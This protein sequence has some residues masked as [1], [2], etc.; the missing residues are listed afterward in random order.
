MRENRKGNE[1]WR[2]DSSITRSG[3]S[4]LKWR[5]W[6]SG[7]EEGEGGVGRAA[8]GGWSVGRLVGRSI[9]CIDIIEGTRRTASFEIA[10]I[11]GAGYRKVAF[12][13]AS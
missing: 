4:R 9:L 8:S 6:S 13:S 11:I 1:R 12:S 3:S 5:R 10:V 7:G 2:G